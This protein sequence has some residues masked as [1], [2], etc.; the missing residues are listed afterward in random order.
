MFA[1]YKG[2]WEL[3]LMAI[4]GSETIEMLLGLF[5]WVLD[6]PRTPRQQ[7]KPQ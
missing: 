4:F 2:T 1:S 3:V 5:P 6:P 7:A